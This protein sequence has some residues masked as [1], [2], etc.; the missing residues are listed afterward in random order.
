VLIREFAQGTP[1]RAGHAFANS[2][3]K[4]AGISG[5]QDTGAAAASS[6]APALS[7]GAAAL[8][9]HRD[10]P[11]TLAHQQNT[12]PTHN[13]KDTP[14][15]APPKR[16]AAA[17]QKQLQ[18]A[19]DPRPSASAPFVVAKAAGLAAPA[20]E[21]KELKEVP[22]LVPP[23]SSL[24][25]EQVAPPRPPA[26]PATPA[27]PPP[28]AAPPAAAEA[29]DFI[30]RK[31]SRAQKPGEAEAK[32]KDSTL[33][34]HSKHTSLMS[35]P[36]AIVKS[37]PAPAQKQV[38]HLL[39]KYILLWVGGSVCLSVCLALSLSR[40]LS[41]SLYAQKQEILQSNAIS[42]HTI[43]SCLGCNVKY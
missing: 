36:K 19:L 16:P 37:L 40:S 32:A 24:A 42:Y 10:T 22:A 34:K 26:P 17:L 43:I 20:V 28:P 5:P 35:L 8:S 1:R 7:V 9:D 38:A 3:T 27:H 41:F 21:H 31:T 18:Q 30:F 14:P 39:Y 6:A 23:C 15:A 33:T 29:E 4:P 12:L 2:D 25:V 13:T 11:P